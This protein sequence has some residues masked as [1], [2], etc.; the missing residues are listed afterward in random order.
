MTKTTKKARCGVVKRH[1]AGRAI[2]CGRRGRLTRR[3]DLLVC[4]HCGGAGESTP[5][6]RRLERRLREEIVQA[7]KAHDVPIT[8]R[9]VRA[10]V[11]PKGARA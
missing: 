9:E 8:P 11:H 10:I 6:V 5:R 2:T 4:E 1:E 7:A 3:G